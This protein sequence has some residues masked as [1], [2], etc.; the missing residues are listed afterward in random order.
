MCIEQLT[1]AGVFEAVKIRKSGY[2]FRLLHRAFA[3]R[4]RCLRNVPGAGDLPEQ[5][6]CFAL[7]EESKLAGQSGARAAVIGKT[8]VLYRAEAYQTLEL[9]RNLALE[10]IVPMTIRQ[11]RISIG[12]WYR[13]AVTAAKAILTDALQQ[14]NDAAKL[15]KA[16]TAALSTLAPF[17]PLPYFD[18]EPPELNMCRELRFKLTERLEVV[19]IFERL[20]SEDPNNCYIEL[21]HTIS[22]AD[23]ITDTPGTAEQMALEES[24]RDRFKNAV[25]FR[26]DPIVEEALHVLD[27]DKMQ[28][29]LKEA[30][31]AFYSTAEIED[32]R[33]KLQLKEEEFVK[34]QLK[35]AN[36]LNDPDRAINREIRLKNLFLDRCGNMF[37]LSNC[38]LLR[39][40]EDWAALKVLTM[41]RAALAQGFLTHS[42]TPIHTSLTDLP[43]A[44]SKIAIKIF[45]CI[46]GYMGYRKVPY[47]EQVAIEMLEFSWND[48]KLRDET[49]VQIMK[50]LNGD[51]Y[52]E[53]GWDLMIL[54][55]NSFPPSPSLE[56]YL[57]YFL[58]ANA[59]QGKLQEIMF[60]LHT[61]MISGG[62]ATVP[63]LNEVPTI[64][65]NFFDRAV[66]KRFESTDCMCLLIP[67]RY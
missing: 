2:P 53:K 21:G 63:S 6:I 10:N 32:I 25:G 50:Q 1:Y 12:R 58:R 36:E 57:C 30:D 16:V 3:S 47:A 7:L 19:A 23:K 17:L 45:K 65:A 41:K 64:I 34:L 15:D 48:Q 56:H 20:V 40:S 5:E 33:N 61:V 51:V 18:F 52:G 14:R 66:N 54:C 67:V 59:P 28:S 49:Y 11:A 42:P 9:L 43:T 39:S 55:L 22:R 44:L 31:E 27:K 24:C 4:Y 60:A 62:R 8:M 46:L 38:H 26:L 29:V 13:S 37:Q 35:R